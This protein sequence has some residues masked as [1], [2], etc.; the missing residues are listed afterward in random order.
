MEQQLPGKIA[1]SIAYVGNRALHIMGSRQLNPAI[2]V[3]GVVATVANENSRRLYSGLGAVTYTDSYEYANYNSLQLNVTRRVQQGLTLLGNVTFSKTIDNSS[4]ATELNPGPPNPQNLDSSRGPADFDQTVRF[5]AAVNYISPKYKGNHFAE[6]ALNGYQFNLI[7][8]IYTGLPFTVLSGTDRSLSGVG[9]DY[10]DVVPG[11]NPKAVPA[12]FTRS[13]RY[14]NIA[15]FAPAALGTFGNASRNSLRGPGFE[16]IDASIF[17]DFFTERRIHGQF[18]AE[19]FN[20][21]NHA[22]LANPVSTV[23]S[24]T[25][26]QITSTVATSAANLGPRVFQFG[27]KILF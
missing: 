7:A 14:F 26:G 20:I 5:N 13:Q 12:G 2:P 10:A 1:M 15:A 24:G 6:T 19:G 4:D 27:A 8:N 16:E 18:R 3:A 21:L 25:F 9:N 17:R 11:Q 22:N 23:N